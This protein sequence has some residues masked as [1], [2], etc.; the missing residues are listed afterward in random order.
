MTQLTLKVA[1]L[2]IGELRTQ[3]RTAETGQKTLQFPHLK[4]D[5][6]RQAK[7]KEAT[8]MSM[9]ILLSLLLLLLCFS[10]CIYIKKSP[11]KKFCNAQRAEM[12]EKVHCDRTMHVFASKAEILTFIR[13]RTFFQVSAHI[14]MFAFEVR[15]DHDDV[16]LF[17]GLCGKM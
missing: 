9:Y 17:T 7:G 6:T 12:W 4:G 3:N 13:K 1:L 16:L 11:E 8:R 15:N 5:A 10:I 14:V 2:P